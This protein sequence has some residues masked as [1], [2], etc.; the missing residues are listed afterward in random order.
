MKENKRIINQY[1]Y[2]NFMDCALAI[3]GSVTP[4]VWKKVLAVCVYACL[5][6]LLSIFI[7]WLSLP[8][9][10]F[11]YAGV[12][13][14]LILVFR[15]NAG[16]DRWWE[17]RKLWGNVVNCSRNLA[18]I[19]ISYIDPSN[20]DE[21]DKILGLIAAMPYLMKNN[22]R[23]IT[24]VDEVK[25][26]LCDYTYAQLQQ[27]QHK[28]NLISS[29]LAE[30]LSQ[31]QKS[32]KLN[33]FSFLKAEELR[34]AILD[35]QGACERI[36][37]TPMPFVMA[38]KSRRFILLFLIILPVALVNYSAYINPIIVTLVAYALFS[39]DQIGVELQ[40]P[41]SIENLSHLPL[42]DICSTIE[43]NVMEIKK[44]QC[45]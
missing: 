45:K 36:L 41:F 13:M 42:N 25:H 15:V 21:I 33:Q 24:S 6:S 19:I 31:M 29:K 40:N 11:E 26:L 4:R 14:G 17:A 32:G 39:L 34:E 12:I 18:I 28:P 7:P 22:L 44:K 8:I 2:P 9:S 23:G 35:C 27:W 3:H 10:P 37:K 20:R 5:I 16:Y 30:M 38:I 43:N 1:E